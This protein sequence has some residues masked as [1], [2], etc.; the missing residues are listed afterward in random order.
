MYADR[1]RYAATAT[2]CYSGPAL[3][4][5]GATLARLEADI[6]RQN[7]LATCRTILDPDKTRSTWQIALD[8]AT[9]IQ[10]LNRIRPSRLLTR[11]EE[12]LLVIDRGAKSARRIHDDLTERCQNKTAT[13]LSINH[14][15]D[16]SCTNPVKIARPATPI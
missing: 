15:E 4:L 10:R 6:E 12:A 3:K 5:L 11:Y 9:A 1:L 13:I 14:T 8:M 7:A 2:G 16:H